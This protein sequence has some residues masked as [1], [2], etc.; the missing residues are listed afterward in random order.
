[1]VEPTAG[2]MPPWRGR[3]YLGFPGSI[4]LVS[5]QWR[6]SD[7]IA[8]H[9]SRVNRLPVGSLHGNRRQPGRT[10]PKHAPGFLT[11]SGSREG[12][13][14]GV[15]VIALS[16]VP[17]PAFGDF[18]GRVVNVADGDTLSAVW[19]RLTLAICAWDRGD[20]HSTPRYRASRRVFKA[21][22]LTIV[23]YWPQAAVYGPLHGWVRVS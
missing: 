10:F 5:G 18:T 4:K 22:R 2:I 1:M 23:R 12:Y 15:L 6:S 9:V 16:V 3:R 14:G 7:V 13:A 11:A 19:R 17:C 21:W 8:W 20:F